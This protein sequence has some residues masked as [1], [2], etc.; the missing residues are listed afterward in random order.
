MKLLL[1]I[2]VVLLAAVLATLYALEDP[3]YVLMARAPWSVEMSL[4]L[5]LPLLLLGF[6]LLY[7]F[8]YL[9][10]RLVRIPRDVSTWRGKKHTRQANTGLY[11]GLIKLAEGNWVEAEA[12]FL[13]SMRYSE[14]PLLTY[15]GAACASAGQKDIEKRDD[16]LAKAHKSSPKNQLAT[17]MI[18]AFLQKNA[19][20][21][22]QA[23]ATLNE[24]R[25]QAPWSKLALKFLAQVYLALRDWT[26]LAD[27][28]PDLRQ[29]EAMT[30]EEIDELELQTHGELLKLSL[31]SGSLDILKKAWNAVPKSLRRQPALIAIYARQLILQ[32]QMEEAEALLLSTLDNQWDDTLVALFGQV[33][34]HDPSDR[35]DTAENWLNNH[36]D[37][38]TLYLTLARLALQNQMEGKARN[39]LE[40]CISLHGPIEAYFELGKLLEKLD[41][42]NAALATYRQGLESLSRVGHPSPL[43]IL[44]EREIK[45]RAAR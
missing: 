26:S 1:F 33:R 18:Q 22:E 25:E 10:V 41:E 39:Y 20:Q 28:I 35:L 21:P 44:N 12:K 3:G 7:L 9:V 34:V 38:P 13:T 30:P 5:F 27:L 42:P 15:L 4:T 32:N 2:L 29:S 37:S 43:R 31:P 14:M 19:R 24:L 36:I 6:L 16:Y 17:S 11:Q 23:L 40:R 8:L 45:Y